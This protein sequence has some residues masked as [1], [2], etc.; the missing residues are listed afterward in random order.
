LVSLL[1][2]Y[3]NNT[4]GVYKY[5]TCGATVQASNSCWSDLDV[6]TAVD[7]R[8]RAACI[9][10][11]AAVYLSLSLSLLFSFSLLHSWPTTKFVLLPASF[12]S[13]YVFNSPCNAK[14]NAI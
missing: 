7:L 9:H 10:T 11:K 6:V 1:L 12:T 2:T 8:G 13:Q 5:E 3:K 4:S 14:A